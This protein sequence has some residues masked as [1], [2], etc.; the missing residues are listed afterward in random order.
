[1]RRMPV[2]Q[3]IVRLG[4]S[5]KMRLGSALGNIHIMAVSRAEPLTEGLQGF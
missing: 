1:M 3:H 2:R 4:A 5:V